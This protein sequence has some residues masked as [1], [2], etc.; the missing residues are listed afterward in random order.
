MRGVRKLVRSRVV[1]HTRDDQSIRGILTASYRD[2]FV[3]AEPQYLGEAQPSDLEGRAVI[4][5]DNVAWL[6]VL[7]S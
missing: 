7:G 2:C 4:L 5:R 1:V 3:L 6:Q